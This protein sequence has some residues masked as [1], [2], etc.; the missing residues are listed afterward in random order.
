MKAKK[1]P[2]IKIKSVVKFYVVLPIWV[3]PHHLFHRHT[4]PRTL[5]IL[6]KYVSSI[7]IMSKD[8]VL[9]FHPPGGHE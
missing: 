9:C 7:P 5:H 3:P 2:G 8:D 1:R 6:E 4:K